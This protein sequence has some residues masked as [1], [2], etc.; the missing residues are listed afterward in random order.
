M[1]SS[2]R[3]FAAAVA[4]SAAWLGGGLGWE[5]LRFGLSGAGT[6]SRL[7]REVRHKF[8]TEAR[9]VESLARRVAA[10]SSVRIA[11]AAASPDRLPALFDDLAARALSPSGENIALTVYVP[12][13][14]VIRSPLNTARPDE[15]VDAVAFVS[16]AL[17]PEAI[18]A[19]MATP[20]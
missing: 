4:I 20:A 2:T 11:E 1:S 16:V 12:D 15:F 19:V 6:A 18:C 10:E 8:D 7:E 14:P 13:G 5:A 17:G 9:Q 3:L